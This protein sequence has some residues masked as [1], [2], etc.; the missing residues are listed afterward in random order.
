[1]KTATTIAVLLYSIAYLSAAENKVEGVVSAT[2]TRSGAQPAHYVFTRK[3][4]L[5][6]IENTDNK[7]EPVNIIDL[8]GKKVT[9]VYP[10]NS[11]FVRVDL[12]A[13]GA[14]AGRPSLP[15]PA[16]ALPGSTPP[17]T[18]PAQIGPSITPPPGFPTP[19]SMPAMP[20]Q[21]GAGGPGMP[22]MPMMPPPMAGMSQAEELKKTEQ[23]KK[24][25]GL[26]CTLYTIE[27]RGEKFDLW[28]ASDAALFPFRLIERDFLGRRFGP[29]MLEETWPQLLRDKSLF[30]IEAT[31]KMEPGSQERLSFKVE[32]IEKKKIDDEKLFQPP[33]RY[34]EI[35]AP[36]F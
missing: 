10:H 5:V 32:K 13:G 3:G 6:R 31:L 22:P 7:L 21:Q 20:N 15:N 8:E 17:A 4:A 30:P 33:E 2:L 27:Q 19:P 26:D 1:M 12:V 14:D 29:Q 16:L 25:Q 34:I 9:I 36:H 23:T 18:M 35:Q 24:I 28:V 11:T